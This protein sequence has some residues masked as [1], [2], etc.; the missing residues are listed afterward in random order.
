[1]T[2]VEKQ[3]VLDVLNSLDVIE[4]NG[5]EDA[6]ILVENNQENHERLN[7]VGITSETIDKYGDEDTFCILALAFSEGYCD[8]YEMGK[9]IAFDKSLEV[10]V[11][12]GN[13]IILY[14]QDG[15]V[16][17]TISKDGGRI[18]TVRLTSEQ[19]Q[20]IKNVIA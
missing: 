13:S 9:L 4:T 15:E 8:L 7:E 6:Y 18:E 17:L 16:Y 2:L 19:L 3:K 14:K 10:E 12:E 11:S 1:M 20:E 5:G